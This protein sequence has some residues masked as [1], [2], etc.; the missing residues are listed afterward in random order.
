MRCRFRHWVIK[1]LLHAF[2]YFHVAISDR[3]QLPDWRV[4][5]GKICMANNGGGFCS[6]QGIK[7]LD[8]IACEKLNKSTSS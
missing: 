1:R 8:P 4:S 6:Q 2:S 5:C 7:T 3:R